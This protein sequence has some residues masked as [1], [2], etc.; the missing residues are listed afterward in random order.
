M[1]FDTKYAVLTAAEMIAA[2]VAAFKSGIPAYALMAK[3][4]G[5]L[6]K[7]ILS[8]KKSGKILFLNG[9]GNNGG[10]GWVAAE[11]LR[12]KG[13]DVL[14]VA[15]KLPDGHSCAALTAYEKWQGETGEFPDNLEGYDVI[16]DALFGT[17]L[18]RPVE[19]R[20]AKWINAANQ[21]KAFKVAVDIPSGIS[22]DTGQILGTAFKADLTAT[23]SHKKRGQMLMPGL[24]LSGEVEIVDI[25]IGEEA[26]GGMALKVF[27][28]NPVLWRDDFP[29]LAKGG[30]KHQ[31]GHLLVA[32]G[33]LAMS[34]AARMAARSALRT[35][36][37][38][39]TTLV[40]EKALLAY[41]E[42]Q[43]SVMSAGYRDDEEFADLVASDK[44][45]AFV[46]G[47]GN[48]VGEGTRARVLKVLAAG[49]P[50]VLDADALTSFEGDVGALEAAL[51]E[52]CVLTPHYGEFKRLW[53]DISWGDKVAAAETAAAKTGA[54]VLLKGPDTVISDGTITI[55]NTH[56][57]PQ[58]ATAGSG[59]VLAGI[60]AG[61]MTQ[62]MAPF[63]AAAAGA[64]LHGEAALIFGGGLIAD[65]LIET[66]PKV[67]KS[68]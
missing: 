58:L 30:H 55:I 57:A 42:K 53:P 22:S 54:I 29:K 12:H 9:P 65:D 13:W 24:E 16:V 59:D 4:G 48:G 27:E 49:K 46:I 28:N 63:L 26:L 52:K 8:K 6:A 15:L 47:P 44:F 67:L 45:G 62:G 1:K 23:F 5:G 36:A 32:G 25:G 56:A 39:V 60:I 35:G 20:A 41:A 21:A 40:P 14:C 33:P 7:A 38:L 37:G 10:D 3:A 43:L 50:C 66:L 34:G 19:G 2:E 64:W 51:H 11:I 17:G 61:L 68:L 31:R 18:E